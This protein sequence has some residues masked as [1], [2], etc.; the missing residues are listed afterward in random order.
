M[1]HQLNQS[2]QINGKEPIFTPDMMR[3]PLEDEDDV[4]HTAEYK[5]TNMADNIDKTMNTE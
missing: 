2:Q 3:N 4:Y 1:S 5:D